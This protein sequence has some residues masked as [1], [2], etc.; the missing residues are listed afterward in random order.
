MLD[1][2]IVAKAGTLLLIDRITFF[3]EGEVL[4]IFRI[5]MDFVPHDVLQEYLKMN[6]SHAEAYEFE[7]SKFVD[8]LLAHSY[9]KALEYDRFY[10]GGFGNHDRVRYHV[11][12]TEGD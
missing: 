6:P 1:K 2:N 5:E 11:F 10:L 12:G 7:E 3:D 4:G 9:M 8:Y